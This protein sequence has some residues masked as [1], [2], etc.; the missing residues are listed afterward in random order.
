[1][2]KQQG[3]FFV[4]MFSFMMDLPPSASS[5]TQ[6]LIVPYILYEASI[7]SGKE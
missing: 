3:T 7:D 4:P 5:I 6:I 2:T 1:M